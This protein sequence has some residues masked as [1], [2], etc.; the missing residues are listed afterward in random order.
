MHPPFYTERTTPVP[1]PSPAVLHH[2]TGRACDPRAYTNKSGAGAATLRDMALRSVCWHIRLCEPAA[3]EGVGWWPY[4]GMVWG[5]LERSNTLTLAAWALFQAAFPAQKEIAHAF[6]VP[7]ECA[8][9]VVEY[10]ATLPEAVGVCVALPGAALSRALLLELLKLRGLRVLVHCCPRQ[11]APRLGIRELRDWSRAAAEGVGGQG[12]R[13]LYLSAVEHDSSDRGVLGALGGLGGLELVGIERMGIQRAGEEK[14][15]R[16]EGEGGEWVRVDGAQEEVYTGIMEGKDT[17][18]ERMERLVRTV[19]D[20]HDGGRD[21]VTSECAGDAHQDARKEIGAEG[22]RRGGEEEHGPQ[23]SL[24]CYGDGNA[25]VLGRVAW[26]ARRPG[27][28]LDRSDTLG[29]RTLDTPGKGVP[30]DGEAKKR[31]VKQGKKRDVGDMLGGF[32]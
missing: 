8:P 16:F 15:A 19:L 30:R 20:A 21:A 28:V 22:R 17:L 26:Y 4:G 32:G 9:S 24:T 14:R 25:R 3:L 13:V 11:T 27:A 31:R 18:G 1:R 10:L 2:A 12:L 7:V 23:L 5:A 6:R 29:K